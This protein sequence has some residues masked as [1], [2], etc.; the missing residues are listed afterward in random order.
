MNPFLLQAKLV[1]P[2]VG[3]SLQAAWRLPG[4][5]RVDR[6]G[7]AGAETPGWPKGSKLRSS[8]PGGV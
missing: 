2:A 1:T 5:E 7:P 8:R 6:D 3:W 4:Q